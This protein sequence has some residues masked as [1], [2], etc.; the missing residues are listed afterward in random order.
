MEDFEKELNELNELKSLMEQ[1]ESFNQTE[2]MDESNFSFSDTNFDFKIKIKY[3]NNS[4]NPD[5]EYATSGSSGFDLR[6]YLDTPMILNPHT[7]KIVPTGLYFEIP[8]NLEIQVRSRSSLS[9]KHGVAVLN[10]PGTIDSDYRGE[11][12]VILINHSDNDFIINNG[13]R[14]AQG[15]ISNVISK[16]IVNFSKVDEIDVNTERGDGGYGSTGIN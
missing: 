11:I 5:P 13:D 3:T 1:I 10:S 15:V 7:I 4:N 6:A 16:N 8:E 9:A 14:I 2:N 12:G